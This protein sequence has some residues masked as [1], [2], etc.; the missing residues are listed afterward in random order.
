MIKKN[1]GNVS[2]RYISKSFIHIVISFTLLGLPQF[3]HGAEGDL[4][5]TF[6]GD[7]KVI[8]DFGTAESAYAVDIQ[9]DGKIVAVGNNGG[10]FGDC[11]LARYNSDGSLDTTF[12][13]DGKV[14]T[15]FGSNDRCSLVKIQSDGKIVIAG[16]NFQDL[17]LAR[18]N[19]NGSLDL[20]F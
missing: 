1:E 16:T 15:N 6:D 19:S 20:S 9:A 11:L 2:L 4:D 5:P 14:V 17:I 3:L 8:T 13:G 7:G 10:S 18:Y 12:D